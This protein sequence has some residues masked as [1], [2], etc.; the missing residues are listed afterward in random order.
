MVSRFLPSSQIS[1]RITI[2]LFQISV[3]CEKCI[4][5]WYYTLL[6]I[7]YSMQIIETGFVEQFY[8]SH[9][10]G[11]APIC[12]ENFREHSLKRDLSNDAT[13]NPSLFSLVNTFNIFSY[14]PMTLD[15]L[16]PA[17]FGKHHTIALRNNQHT[18]YNFPF[19]YSQKLF[20]KPN[21]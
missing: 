16:Q 8:A 11:P 6:G 21:F 15:S 1:V 13:A 18:V 3:L 5:A 20:A 9:R 10:M 14:W 19:M 4:A 2:P 12:F 7:N 17:L